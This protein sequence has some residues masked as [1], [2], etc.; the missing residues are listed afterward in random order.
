VIE[1]MNGK[2]RRVV[3]RPL[4]EQPDPHRRSGPQA[5]TFMEFQERVHRFAEE[6]LPQL[7][8]GT[9]IFGMGSGAGCCSGCRRGTGADDASGVLAF[10][11]SSRGCGCLT[12]GQS[13]LGIQA[14]S[15]KRSHLVES[16]HRAERQHGGVAA[17]VCH[18]LCHQRRSVRCRALLRVRAARADGLIKCG[19]NRPQMEALRSRNPEDSGS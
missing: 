8:A 11:R 9:V 2:E 19:G 3:V 5:D 7:L 10:R 4:W 14:C 1:G 16:S 18:A 17:R 15:A 12:A 13:S 6:K